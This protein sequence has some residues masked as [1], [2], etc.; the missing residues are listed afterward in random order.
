MNKN[1]Q[2]ALL[3]AVFLVCV[4]GGYF[5][6][7]VVVPESEPVVEEVPV[8]EEPV[9]VLSTIPVIESVSSLTGKGGK[10]SFAVTASVES[11]DELIYGLY[12]DEQC[13]DNVAASFDGQFV[14]VPG[15]DSR[16]YYVK[17][18]NSSTAEQSE[19]IAVEGFAKIVKV[20]KVTKEDLEHL[21]NVTKSWSAAPP[22]ILAGVPTNVQIQVL[23]QEV[24]KKRSVNDICMQIESGVWAS[25]T[26]HGESLVYD[27]QDKLIRM[28]IYVNR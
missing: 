26:V 10:Y 4:A 21:F 7:G 11:G 12:R 25:V 3:V 17:V 13:L 22:K 28:T 14:D 1:S 23:N 24:E 19:V 2:I 15:T 20:A 8:V 27:A 18:E 6:G 16:I 9:V 5:L